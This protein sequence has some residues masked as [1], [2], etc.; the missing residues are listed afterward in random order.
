M[1]EANNITLPPDFSVL[2]RAIYKIMLIVRDVF[3]LKYLQDLKWPAVE[4]EPI[5][6]RERHMRQG[7]SLF[8]IWCINIIWACRKRY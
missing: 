2:H 7:A 8:I 3:Q 4:A 1:P 6:D 5:A